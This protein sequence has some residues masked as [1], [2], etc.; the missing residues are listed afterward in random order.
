MNKPFSTE[1]PDRC[2]KISD[3]IEAKAFLAALGIL[4]DLPTKG[5]LTNSGRAEID[6]IAVG[7]YDHPT[8]W[9]LAFRFHGNEEEK[10]NGFAVFGWP[11]NKWPRSVI[12]DAID[13]QS[14]GPPDDVKVSRFG[15]DPSSLS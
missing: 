1:L 4:N 6:T 13:R 12:K 10:E 11:K 3:D 2:I 7:H 8:H 9:I 14:L 15:D 5:T